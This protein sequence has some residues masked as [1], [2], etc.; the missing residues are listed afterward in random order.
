MIVAVDGEKMVLLFGVRSDGSVPA[1]HYLLTRSLSEQATLAHTMEVVAAR[2]L[3]PNEERFKV[4]SGF[5]YTLVAF[6]VHQVRILGV[7]AGRSGDKG[8]IVLTHGF[9]KKRDRTPPGEFDRCMQ[10]FEEMEAAARASTAVPPGRQE[11][12]RKR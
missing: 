2:R 5:K 6:K 3:H 7:M 10:L 9:T 8:R 1:R 11:T 4:E 12:R